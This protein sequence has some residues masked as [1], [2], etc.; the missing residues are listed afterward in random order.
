MENNRIRDLREDNF[1]T[2]EYV[3]KEIGVSRVNYTRYELN[4]RTIPLDI[5]FKIACL[6]S[7]SV[8]YLCGITDDRVLKVYSNYFNYNMLTENLIKLRKENGYSQEELSKLVNTAQNTISEYE[9]G[10]R[11]VSIDFLI[12]LSSLYNKTLDYLM[13]LED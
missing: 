7:V 2:Q 11:K 6:Y 13:G 9:S 4:I 5:L 3:A 12:V 1:Y 10:I 8:D